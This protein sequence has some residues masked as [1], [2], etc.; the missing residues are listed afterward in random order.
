M[1]ETVTVEENVNRCAGDG[2]GFGHPAVYL[3]IGKKEEV[4]CPY[5]GKT[6]I[7]RN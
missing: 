5:C 7:H 4:S 1:P 2:Q 3:A 6:F